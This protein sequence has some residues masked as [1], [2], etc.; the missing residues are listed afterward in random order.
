[1]RADSLNFSI[2]HIE[3]ALPADTKVGRIPHDV[4]AGGRYQTGQKLNSTELEN[5]RSQNRPVKLSGEK[6]PRGNEE[7]L[8][9]P[10]RNRPDCGFEKPRRPMQE[11]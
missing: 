10:H 6:N 7:R 1:M 4:L 3:N 2:L 8:W 11:I 5:N 9:Q